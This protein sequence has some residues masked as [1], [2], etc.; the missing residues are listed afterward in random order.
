[1]P[2]NFAITIQ[3]AD[4]TIV[5][6]G[7]PWY[8]KTAK[9]GNDWQII[10]YDR[11]LVDADQ[12]VLHYFNY[13]NENSYV[14]YLYNYT[15]LNWDVVN[16]VNFEEMVLVSQ[17]NF[18]FLYN[19]NYEIQLNV[20]QSDVNYDIDPTSNEELISAI[21]YEYTNV[22]NYEETVDSNYTSILLAKT[23]T[24]GSTLLISNRAYEYSKTVSNWNDSYFS[25]RNYKLSP[26]I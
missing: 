5:N 19:N 25:F 10:E 20:V 8:Y 11:D 6:P 24:N 2:E 26:N 22:N 18:L 4:T 9:I 15:N 14:H 3:I 23:V 13:V 16:N 7:N 12:Q 1:M 17:N 21:K